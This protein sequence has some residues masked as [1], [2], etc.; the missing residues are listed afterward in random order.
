MVCSTTESSISIL[1][2]F[3]DLSLSICFLRTEALRSWLFV[4]GP[5]SPGS[6]RRDGNHGHHGHGDKPTRPAAAVSMATDQ[7]MR[8][9]VEETYIVSV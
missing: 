5:T 1:L 4:V 2:Y 8:D 6:R 9:N 3:Q 7:A